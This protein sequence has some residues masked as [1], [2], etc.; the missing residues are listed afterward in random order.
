M[1]EKGTSV[2][3][4]LEPLWAS[5]APEAHEKEAVMALIE[6]AR[7]RLRAWIDSGFPD[8]ELLFPHQN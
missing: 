6:E 2:A 4:L 8:P 7:D 5:A 3:Q 1:L